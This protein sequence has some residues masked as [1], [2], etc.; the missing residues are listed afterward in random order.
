MADLARPDLADNG[1]GDGCHAFEFPLRPEWIERRGELSAVVRCEDGAEV[2]VA[3]RIRRPDDAQ[4]A[5][6]LQRAVERLAAEQAELRRDVATRPDPADGAAG[7]AGPARIVGRPPGRAARRRRRVAGEGSAGRR[8]RRRARPVAGG[9][10]RGAGQREQRGAGAGHRPRPGLSATMAE[11]KPAAGRGAGALLRDAIEDVLRAASRWLW[12]VLAMGVVGL[13]LTYGLMQA[14]MYIIG[15]VTVTH[16][17]ESLRLGRRVL[18]DR[19]RHV[20]G[21]EVLPGSL[22]GRHVRLRRAPA[23]GAGGAQHRA[24]ARP[25]GNAGERRDQRHRNAPHLARRP[26]QHGGRGPADDAAP[27]RARLHLALGLRRGRGVLLRASPAC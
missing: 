3:V 1:I 5:T 19:R 10:D 24:A 7:T 8:R 6:H 11:G 22:G 13:L 4:V 15:D 27:G 25:A 12:L 16:S 20:G 26:G 21:A 17:V 14:K 23:R 9:A 18:D 2:P